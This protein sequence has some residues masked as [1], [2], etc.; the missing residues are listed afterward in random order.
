MDKLLEILLSKEDKDFD[1]ICSA[2]RVNG[3]EELV[4]RLK[5]AKATKS[6]VLA[7]RNYELLFKVKQAWNEPTKAESS[8]T[9]EGTEEHSWDKGTCLVSHVVNKMFHDATSCSQKQGLLGLCQLPP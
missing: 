5:E 8:P 6:L 3:H 1:A 2:L 4:V 9:R 7:P